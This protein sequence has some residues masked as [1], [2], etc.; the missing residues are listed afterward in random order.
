MERYIDRPIQN[1]SDCI[2]GIHVRLYSWTHEFGI[3]LRPDLDEHSYRLGLRCRTA[4]RIDPRCLEH[5]PLASLCARRIFCTDPLILRTACGDAGTWRQCINCQS[6]LVV[7]SATEPINFD[8]DNVRH[9][10][11]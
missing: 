2:R 4:D 6:S 9:D 10:W 5:P 8:F 3:L 7:W 11:T 1:V